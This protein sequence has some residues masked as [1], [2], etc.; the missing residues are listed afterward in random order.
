MKPR[1]IILFLSTFCCLHGNAKTIRVHD[2]DRANAV[3]GR[4]LLMEALEYFGEKYQFE[5]VRG[6]D[7][8]A[9]AVQDVVD[10]TVD[11]FWASTSSSLEDKI[12]PIRIPIYK[13]LLGH[14]VFIIHED[15]QARFDKVKTL[16]DIKAV[17]I[18]QGRTWA[19]SD[20]LESNGFNVV[21]AVKYESLFHMVDGGRFDAFSRGVNEPWGELVQRPE[22]DLTV[23]K[24]LVVEYKMP[25]YFFVNNNNVQLAAAIESGLMKMIDDGSFDEFFFNEPMIKDSIKMSDLANRKIFQLNNPNLSKETPIDNDKLWL[26]FSDL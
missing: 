7:V 23:E 24:R 19:D 3:Y 20:I 18:G 15:N 9:R 5:K 21:R 6:T 1:L 10:G 17:S 13:G 16:D 26:N 22:L 14:R 25:M 4:A 2:S 8:T 11:V 12:R